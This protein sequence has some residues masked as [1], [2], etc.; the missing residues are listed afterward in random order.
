MTNTEWWY[1]KQG[2][3]YGPLSNADLKHRLTSEEISIGTH[4]WCKGMSRWTKVADVAALQDMLKECPPPINENDMP[5]GIDLPLDTVNVQPRPTSI[6]TKV[7]SQTQKLH[8]DEN[9]LLSSAAGPWSRL[10]AR[11]I[12]IL[13]FGIVSWAVLFAIYP[14][15]ESSPIFNNEATISFLTIPIALLIEVPL[16]AATGGT[17]GK[18]IFGIKVR[19]SDGSELTMKEILRRNMKLWLHG[20]CLGIPIANLFCMGA[21]YGRVKAG[22][23]CQWD[24]AAMHDVQQKP[25][26][27]LR[28][29]AGFSAYLVMAVGLTALE[30]LDRTNQYPAE[31]TAATWVNPLTGSATRLHSGWQNVQEQVEG[32]PDT[33]WFEKAATDSIVIIGKEEFSGDIINYV[34]ALDANAAFGTLED[35]KAETGIKGTRFYQLTYRLADADATYRM[36]VKVWGTGTA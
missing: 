34:E 25:M 35:K 19:R 22:K 23:H 18:W 27:A 12:D 1:V 14:D 26:G 21:S 33:Y 32:N 6:R 2:E 28:W 15:L 17:L 5:S 36:D 29:V 10:Y 13:V 20:L 8:V 4:V 30:V 24:E 3:R 11:W 16:M 9:F 7:Y 31:T